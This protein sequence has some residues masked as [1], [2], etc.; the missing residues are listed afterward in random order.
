[1]GEVLYIDHYGTLV[2][3]IAGSE[4]ERATGV[5]VAGGHTAAIGRTFGDVEPGA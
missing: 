5:S 3:N 2:T 1:I 4:I